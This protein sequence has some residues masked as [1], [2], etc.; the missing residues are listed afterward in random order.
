M[1]RVQHRKVRMITGKERLS[2]IGFSV[3][4]TDGKES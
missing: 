3:G 2:E 4:I 1:N